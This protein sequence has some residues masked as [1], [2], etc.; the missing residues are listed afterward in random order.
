LEQLG[1]ALEAFGPRQVLVRGVPALIVDRQP[2]RVVQETLVTLATNTHGLVIEQH[3]S[4]AERLAVVLA[5]KSAV[6]AGDELAQPE[7]ESLLRRLSEAALC[8]TCAHGRPTAI[9]LSHAQLE[10]EFGR[11]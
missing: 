4:W 10:K 5:C 9:L 2:Q 7:M 3:A 8:R 6:R 11:R 1:F